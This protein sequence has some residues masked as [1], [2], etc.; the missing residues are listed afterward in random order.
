MVVCRPTDRAR[1]CEKIGQVEDSGDEHDAKL[2]ALIHAVAEPIE[3]HVQGL[4]EYWR[5]GVEHIRSAP[6]NSTAL[7]MT[8]K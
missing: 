4:A 1:F 6:N 2:V 7:R 3:A 8:S 5:H